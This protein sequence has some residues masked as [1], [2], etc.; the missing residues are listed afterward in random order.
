[1]QKTFDA[2]AKSFRIRVHRAVA[3]DCVLSAVLRPSRICGILSPICYG[4]EKASE[5]AYS[6]SR[7]EEE[8][9]SREESRE[10]EEGESREE[11]RAQETA[12]EGCEE[13]RGGQ[14]L[15]SQSRAQ[16]RH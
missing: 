6:A 15:A 11:S 9:E 16:A 12:S 10:T 13:G 8:G 7:A 14:A 1:M 4:E 2:S 3:S 5:K